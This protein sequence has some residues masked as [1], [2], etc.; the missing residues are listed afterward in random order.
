M[1]PPNSFITSF[2]WI[3]SLIY[4]PLANLFSGYRLRFADYTVFSIYVSEVVC[5]CRFYNIFYCNYIVTADKHTQYYLSPIY[6][7]WIV[8]RLN[9][10][11]TACIRT[12]ARVYICW[13][14]VTHHLRIENFAYIFVNLAFPHFL[15]TF[16]M[17]IEC[18]F[19]SHLHLVIH[20]HLNNRTVSNF[21]LR[22]PSV[23]V[24]IKWSFHSIRI[25]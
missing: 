17:S 13:Y 20:S 9:L 25:P 2:N 4:L 21:P 6:S 23:F 18:N 1:Q 15:F 7:V 10:R 8:L 22:F 14:A 19:L 24:N 5:W 3:D 12:H 16:H 11:A